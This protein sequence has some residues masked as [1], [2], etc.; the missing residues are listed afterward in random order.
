MWKV[1]ILDSDLLLCFPSLFDL[2]TLHPH[3]DISLNE[4]DVIVHVIVS[5]T[6]SLLHEKTKK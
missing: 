4:R 6:S 3:E 5:S 1:K 2:K